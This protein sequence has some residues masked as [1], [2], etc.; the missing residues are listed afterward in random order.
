MDGVL[1][2]ASINAIE[3]RKYTEPSLILFLVHRQS[4]LERFV[5]IARVHHYKT[6][7]NLNPSR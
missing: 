6:A 5:A 2:K 3:S 4:S 7:D 1:K